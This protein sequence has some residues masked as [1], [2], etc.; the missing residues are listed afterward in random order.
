MALFHFV[1][2]GCVQHMLH[3][4]KYQNGRQVGHMLGQLIGQELL[5]NQAFAMPDAV[6]PV[7]L[8][9]KKKRIRGY[10]QSELI[11]QGIA[12]ALGKPCR[13][14]LVGR[15]RHTASQTNKNREQRLTNVANAFE[16]SPLAA[17]LHLLLVDDVITTGATLGA[18]GN[19]LLAHPGVKLSIAAAAVAGLGEAD[20]QGDKF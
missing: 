14:G 4:L 2:G 18:C 20:L 8:H 11:A 16:A 13:P 17:N 10:N 5:A 1:A 3:S 6:V 15:V 7:P 9:P 19:A 12:K